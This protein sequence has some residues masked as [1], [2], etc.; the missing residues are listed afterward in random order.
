AGHGTKDKV[1][2]GKTFAQLARPLLEKKGDKELPVNPF[3]NA[4]AGDWLLLE[5][6][7]TSQAKTV[8]TYHRVV[9][10]VS[11]TGDDVRVL[12]RPL[13]HAKKWTD[14]TPP[15][16]SYTYSKSKAP[17]VSEVLGFVGT[18]AAFA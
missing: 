2:F 10:I 4:A 16:S 17:L 13:Q 8:R 15:M 6:Q 18:N 14:Y 7:T 1:L 9:E 3:A 12:T 11:V 5:D